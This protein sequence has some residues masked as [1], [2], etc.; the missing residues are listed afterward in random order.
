VKKRKSRAPRRR[1]RPRSRRAARASGPRSAPAAAAEAPSPAGATQV[2]QRGLPLAAELAAVARTAGP[3]R[4][5]LERA[6]RVLFAAYGAA[7]P[8]FSGLL[9]TGWAR[10]RHD[11]QFRLTLAWQREQ[12][13]LC[14]EDILL[15]GVRAGGFRPD[16]DAGAAAAVIVGAAEG[17]LLQAATDGGAVPGDRL[18]KSL[19]TLALSGA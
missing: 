10:A 7:D 2:E 6:M 9:L 13:R 5:K 18:V 15:E 3:P 17:C 4:A 11:K 19:L 8:D 12:I 14:L 16:L 1:P